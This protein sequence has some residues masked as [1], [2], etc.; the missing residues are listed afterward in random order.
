MGR[1]KEGCGSRD[2]ELAALREAH[3]AAQTSVE[4]LTRQAGEREEDAK[5]LRQQARATGRYTPLPTCVYAR[6]WP[7]TAEHGCLPPPAKYGA[8]S[9]LTVLV[10]A[11]LRF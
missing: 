9:Q 7:N 10:D 11:L 8:S 6:M 1:C 5:K 3:H 4:A 2:D